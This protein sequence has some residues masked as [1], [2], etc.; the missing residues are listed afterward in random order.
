MSLVFNSNR[1]NHRYKPH[2]QMIFGVLNNW[3]PKTKTF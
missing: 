1:I 3:D 2:E